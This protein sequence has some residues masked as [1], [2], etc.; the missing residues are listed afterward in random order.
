MGETMVRFV[1]R[2][3]AVFACLGIVCSQAACT[4]S[5]TYVWFTQLPPQMSAGRDEY[6]ISAG[7]VLNVRVLGHD[8]MNVREKV[9]PDGR[10][11]IPIV[12]EIEARGKRPGALRSELEA[13]LKDYIV[14]PSVLLNVDEPQPITI[15]LMGEV[16][17]PGVYPLDP[18]AGLAHAL[19]LGG[20]LT[21]FASRDSI[22]VVRQ[23]PSPMRIRFTYAALTR[24][25][26]RAA[27]FPLHPGDLIV[28]E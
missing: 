6:L 10:M 16:T 3:S 11:A 25:I 27:S 22:Y 12:G 26:G 19:A 14:M 8:E 17:R 9:R 13:R 28:A 23:L 24:N 5:G 2:A 1:R 7:D 15:I 20:G 4:G 18:N 21:D